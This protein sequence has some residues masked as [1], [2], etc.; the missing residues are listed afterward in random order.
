MLLTICCLSAAQ[1]QWLETTIPIPDSFGV[2]EEPQCLAYNATNT[3]IYVGGRDGDCVIAIDGATNQRIARIPT[4]KF[5]LD[6][7]YNSTNNKVYCVV[8]DIVT[9]I[10]GATDSV[11]AN[12]GA[13]GTHALSYNPINNRVYCADLYATSSV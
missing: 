4:G 1:A 2:L 13:R 9:V 5:V 10:D 7:C 3:T 8:G 11:I 12:V 6:L